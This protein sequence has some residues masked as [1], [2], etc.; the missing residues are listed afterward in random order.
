MDQL[1]HTG[2]LGIDSKFKSHK[3]KTMNTAKAKRLSPSEFYRQIRPEYFS[4][5]EIT[6]ETVLT[7]EQLAFEL[8]QISKNQ[9]QDQFETLCRRL[10]EK[11]VSPNLIPQVGP[12]GGGDSKVDTETYRVSTE[13]SDRWFV[14]ENGWTK[15]EKWG[16]AISA[17]ED[18]NS[19]IKIDVEKIVKTNRGYTQIYFLTNQTPSS[20]K[21]AETQDKLK[22]EYNVDVTILDG[23]W[24]LE[25]I[26]GNDLTELVVDSL[27]LSDVFK[28]KNKV[29]GKN[30]AS[31]EKKLTELEKDINT[32]N[33]Y[34]DSDFQL[35]EDCLEATILARMLERPRVVVDGMFE[36]TIRFSNKVNNPKQRLRIHYQRAWTNLNFYDDAEGFIAELRLFKKYI[37]DSSTPSD[38]ELYVNLFN[39]LKGAAASEKFD[40][41]ALGVSLTSEK[42]ELIIVL[43]KVEGYSERRCSS[44]VAK[45][46]KAILLLMDTVTA[47]QDAD[48]FL[49]S[50]AESLESSRGFIEFPFEAFRD[51]IEVF[52]DVFPGNQQFDHLVETIA[53]IS[54]ARSSE[55]SAGETFL[56]RGIQKLEVDLFKDS[57]VYFGKAV[58]KL[59]KEESHD[60]MYLSLIGLSHAYSSLGLIWAS[61]NCLACA[62]NISLT[63][64][65]D[66]GVIDKR[67]YYCAKELAIHEILIGRIPSFFAFHEL[68]QVVSDRLNLDEAQ[69]DFNM[70]DAF[71]AIRILSMEDRFENNISV[72]PTVLK[73][74]AL[75]LSED[76]CYYRLGYIEL[77]E[78]ILLGL[79]IKKAGDIDKHFES[80]YKQPF[81]EQLLYETDFLDHTTTTFTSVILGCRFGLTFK[82]EK[83]LIIVAETLLAFFE[84][85]FATSLENV[86]P[87]S[88]DIKIEILKSSDVQMFSFSAKEGATN[89]YLLNIN[90]LDLPADDK[91]AFW[92]P[93]WTCVSLLISRNLFVKDFHLHLENL[94]KNEEIV[95]R[96]ALIF[97]HGKFLNN[98]LGD[99]SGSQFRDWVDESKVQRF[100]SKRIYPLFPNLSDAHEARKSDTGEPP[101]FRHDNRIVESVIETS[102]WDAA[103]WRAFGF[104]GDS[105]GMVIFLAYENIEFG[106]KIF[107][108][109]IKRFGQQDETEAIK[110]SIIRGVHSRNPNWYKVHIA[111]NL[112]VR[113]FKPGKYILSASRFHEINAESHINLQNL[114]NGFK[115]F[116][117][118]RFCPA[119]ITSGAGIQPILDS[120]IIKKSL[121]VREAWEIGPHDLDSVVIR[122]GD[123]PIIPSNMENPPVNQLLKQRLA[124]QD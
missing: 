124:E 68:A 72:L 29:V 36:R 8:S 83:D 101:K 107:D 120:A 14:P 42:D 45:T 95:E 43:T 65:R 58:L 114:I 57:I 49:K 21:K 62:C 78:N 118:Y 17:K 80:L 94:F 54:E 91:D 115:H 25:K 63:S 23:D 121:I 64:W 97:S 99:K 33:R 85:F 1:E 10:A 52:G 26:F 19:K 53:S 56:K 87:S 111:S 77:I 40:F 12:T 47:G 89:E 38:L 104:F 67:T 109:W 46:Y 55:L 75:W 9:K 98:V 3:L 59:A 27:G 44:L 41:N 7:R 11:F 2:H 4:D 74:Q 48:D 81:R 69:H 20:K 113:S 31:R 6:Y 28:R 105:R 116:K 51:L 112:D 32:P 18:W 5:S 60:R 84:A 13:I 82:T 71:L 16:F 123:Q 15:N 79:D 70:I 96:L 50:L 117:Q 37:S 39:L 86:F 108:N 24:I 103:K 100:P 61:S 90:K 102:L 30:D 66:K 34:S 88:A 110:I 76:S 106:K 22:A 73:N 35:V 119:K 92:A 122:K 93:I